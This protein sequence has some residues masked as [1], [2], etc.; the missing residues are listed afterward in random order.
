MR[1]IY[2]HKPKPV[3]VIL[4]EITNFNQNNE[5]FSTLGLETFSDLNQNYL[6]NKAYKNK[7]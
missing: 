7:T 3:P 2:M 1:V 4:T 6:N 5:I